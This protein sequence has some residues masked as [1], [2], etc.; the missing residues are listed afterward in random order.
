MKP[1]SLRWMVPVLSA[2][3]LSIVVTFFG[4]IAYRAVR[5]STIDVAA[6]RLSTAVQVLTQPAAQ[7]AP[8]VRE[9]QAVARHP[10]VREI[11]LSGGRRVSDSARAS[12]STLTPDTGLTLLTDV[13]TPNGT[14]LYS[15]ASAVAESLLGRPRTDS[16]K[17]IA[18]EA[19]DSSDMSPSLLVSP[20]RRQQAYPDS[21]TQSPLYVG[22]DRM[23]YERAVPVRANGRLVGHVVQVRTVAIAPNALRQLAGLIGK[24]A[25]LVI[26]NRDGS[27]WTDLTKSISHP[28]IAET[29]QTYER[30]GRRWITATRPV[31]TGPWVLAAELPEDAVLA[32]VHAL[33]WRLFWIGAAIVVIAVL[34]TER[35]SRRLTLPLKGLTTAAEEIAAGHRNTPVVALE[36]SDEVGRLSRA[37]VAMAD[38]IRYSHDTLEHEIGERTHDLQATLTRLQQA[39]EELVRQERLATL[40]QLSGSIAHEL[41]NPLGVM[42]NALY[43]LDTVL[44]DAQPKVRA[45]LAKLKAQVRLSESI[46]TGLLN[47]TRTGAPSLTSVALQPLLD[48]QLAHA[49]VPNNVRVHLEFEPGLPELQADPVQVGQ[50]L[51]NLLT[52]AVQAMD[53]QPGVLTVR[54]HSIGRRAVRIEVSDTGPGIRDADRERVFEPLFTTKARGIGLGLSVARSLARANDGELIVA[55][56]DGPGATLALE[57]P[58]AARVDVQPDEGGGGRTREA[59]TV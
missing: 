21:V 17:A 16:G 9:I 49:A 58:A 51:M 4:A 22:R 19:R 29:A 28:P 56:S 3:I 7:P 59:A 13:R 31:A 45:H 37:F 44:G 39:Q 18:T 1:V 34:L 14:V 23:L 27:V 8:W 6:E 36:R 26:G 50:I 42:T 11:I 38:S 2:A 40:G 24:D 35:L 55:A 43:Y 41:R 30:D 32:P 25:A 15:I 20:L 57:L 52:N 47:V 5:D 12:I 54:A 46:I 33:R 53:G 48:E 10:A